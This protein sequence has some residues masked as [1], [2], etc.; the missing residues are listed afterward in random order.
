MKEKNGTNNKRSQA[1]DWYDVMKHSKKKMNTGMISQI[2]SQ[3][4]RVR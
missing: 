2:K 1:E 4:K 3:G